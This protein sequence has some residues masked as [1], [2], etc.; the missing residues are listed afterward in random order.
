MEY[1]SNLFWR[2]VNVWMNWCNDAGNGF[3]EAFSRRNF[4]TKFS[5]KVSHILENSEI[6]QTKKNYGIWTSG[7]GYMRMWRSLYHVQVGCK[8][9]FKTYFKVWLKAYFKVY[10][11]KDVGPFPNHRK[12]IEIF[13][14]FDECVFVGRLKT[15]SRG[16]DTLWVILKRFSAINGATKWW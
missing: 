7:S 3:F 16:W 5:T 6:F 2:L 8:V 11:W 13:T 1:F 12:S 9:W 15:S 14:N 10:F 4:Q